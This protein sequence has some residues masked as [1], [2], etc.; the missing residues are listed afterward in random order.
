MTLD[1]VCDSCGADIEFRISPSATAYI[2]PCKCT[3]EPFSEL[4]SAFN[5]LNDQYDALLDQLAV[6]RKHAPEL[7]L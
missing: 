4:E 3:T 1:L 7:F 5:E 2:Y 6:C